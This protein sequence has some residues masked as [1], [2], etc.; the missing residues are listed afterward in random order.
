MFVL[1]AAFV[2]VVSFYRFHGGILALQGEI[3]QNWKVVSGHISSTAV[4]KSYLVSISDNDKTAEIEPP[5]TPDI[6][7][8]T[9]ENIVAKSPAFKPGKIAIVQMEG[10]PDL[11]EYVKHDG[12]I[13]NLRLIQ[14]SINPKI[15]MIQEGDYDLPHLYEYLQTLP[16]GKSLL[17]K[18]DGGVYTLG[19]PLMIARGASL[20]IRGEDVKELRLSRERGSFISNSGNLFILKTRIV[21][22]SDK[23]NAPTAFLGKRVFRPFIN[24]WSGAQFYAAGS[25]FDSL[26]YLRGKSYGIS[27]SSCR[28]CLESSPDLARPTGALVGNTF[29]RLYYGFYSYEADDVAIVGNVYNNNIIYGIDPHDRSRR[30]IIAR[31]ET[32]GTGKKH[33]IIVSREVR[34]SWIFENYSHDNHGS[35]I[36][37]DRAS[38]GNTIA[39]NTAA[40]NKGDGIVLF[41]SQDILSYNNRVFRN[42]RSGYRIRNSWNTKL[43]NDQ[44]TDNHAPPIVIYTSAL[45]EV[46]MERNFLIDPYVKRSTAELRGVTFRAADGKPAIKATNIDHMKLSGLHLLSSGPIFSDE[47]FADETDM[48]N[49]LEDPSK[50][51]LVYKKT[52]MLKLMQRVKEWLP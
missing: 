41:E 31:N 50:D 2:A 38:G 3:A 37:I 10:M 48:R 19:F 30:L 40:Y 42:E 39:N 28:F 9:I 33:G 26:G 29:T 35:G 14:R 24:V 45:E 36:M 49:A 22:W 17:E 52:K 21:G 32:Y 13:Q 6:S 15:I 5:H 46:D 25:V 12:R 11:R 1:L 34:N 27:F 8:F 43:V 7:Q 23:E 4:S 47:V 16:E 20:T 18:Q 44:I 51:A